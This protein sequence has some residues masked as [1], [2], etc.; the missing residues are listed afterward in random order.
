MIVE[1]KKGGG[2]ERV[3]VSTTVIPP[4]TTFSPDG[5]I[6]AADV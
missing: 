5:R 4:G 1:T 6:E 3:S 2:E